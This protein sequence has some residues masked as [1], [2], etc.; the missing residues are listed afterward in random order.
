MA[1]RIYSRW[2]T[3]PICPAAP[4]I[5]KLSPLSRTPHA[6]GAAAAGAGAGAGERQQATLPQSGRH[7]KPAAA[8]YLPPIC[9]MTA[10]MLS[11]SSM[12]RSSG[13]WLP[14]RRSPSKRNLWGGGGE[15]GGLGRGGE[16]RRTAGG[17]VRRGGAV[18]RGANAAFPKMRV[19]WR[20]GRE[21]GAAASKGHTG[22]Q[23]RRSAAPAPAER[24]PAAGATP[25]RGATRH[26][27]SRPA[28]PH[29]PNLT[30]NPS[31]LPA[32]AID[33]PD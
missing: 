19:V 15:C 31:V 29:S 4:A 8:S 21:G 26:E 14:C 23:R 1:A 32:C 9:S 2:P 33:S 17:S 28:A 6:A 11:P 27:L 20:G 16:L 7:C 5:V 18:A 13:V 25:A 12:P 3:R 10:S 22:A 24:R 30:S